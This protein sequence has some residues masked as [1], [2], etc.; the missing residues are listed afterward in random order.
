MKKVKLR[1]SAKTACKIS[2]ALGIVT[3][4]G[5]ITWIIPGCGDTVLA[6][7]TVPYHGRYE[8][9]LVFHFNPTQS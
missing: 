4:F 7:A 2:F 5:S 6:G 3:C 9:V 8:T 1:D